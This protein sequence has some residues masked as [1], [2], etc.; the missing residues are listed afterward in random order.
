MNSL[1][2]GMYLKYL[3]T[4]QAAEVLGVTHQRVCKML[5]DGVLKGQKFGHVWQVDKAAVEARKNG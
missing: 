2:E 1:K 3:T 4:K 5:K